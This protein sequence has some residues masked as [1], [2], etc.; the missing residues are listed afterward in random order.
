MQYKDGDGRFNYKF[1]NAEGA[2]LS[3]GAG[4]ADARACAMAIAALKSAADLGADTTRLLAG[5]AVVG[6]LAEGAT[7]EALRAALVEL[8]AAEQAKG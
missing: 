2:L 5:G 4:Y 3:I 7:L 8:L 1:Q 6:A